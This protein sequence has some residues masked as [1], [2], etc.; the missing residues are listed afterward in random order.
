MLAHAAEQHGGIAFRSRCH[1]A[2]SC[3]AELASD[4]PG[5]RCSARLPGRSSQQS[6]T[7]T[8]VL[9]RITIRRVRPGREQQLRRWFAELEVFGH[10][11]APL[12]NQYV[13]TPFHQDQV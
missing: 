8:P 13:R 6:R 7:V 2:R 10:A 3:R 1:D 12:R 9:L 11:A 5:L 4:T